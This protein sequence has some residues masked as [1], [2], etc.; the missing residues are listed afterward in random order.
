VLLL[1]VHVCVCD[2]T[3]ELL[4][5]RLLLSKSYTISGTVPTLLLNCTDSVLPH[6]F[7]TRAMFSGLVTVRSCF[8]LGMS[9][10]RWLPSRNLGSQSTTVPFGTIQH[11][12]QHNALSLPK[13]WHTV[14]RKTAPVWID[15]PNGMPLLSHTITLSALVDCITLHKCFPVCLL[16]QRRSCAIHSDSVAHASWKRIGQKTGLRNV[17]CRNYRPLEHPASAVIRRRAII[18]HL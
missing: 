6:S 1:R 12:R 2:W 18:I 11:R 14:H 4:Q 9:V 16:S 5:T 10:V 15:S 8:G 7:S 13:A 17:K 3:W